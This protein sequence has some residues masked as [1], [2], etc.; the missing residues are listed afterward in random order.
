MGSNEGEHRTP[1]RLAWGRLPPHAAMGE[2]VHHLGSA[3]FQRRKGRLVKFPAQLLVARIAQKR[4]G[5]SFPGRR[6]HCCL[7][8]PW[9]SCPLSLPASAVLHPAA[10]TVHHGGVPGRAARPSLAAGEYAGDGDGAMVDKALL[11]LPVVDERP[12][13][14]VFQLR[15]GGREGIHRSFGE[16][17]AAR[18]EQLTLAGDEHI[19]AA[20]VA[21]GR[22]TSRWACARRSRRSR[23]RPRRGCSCNSARRARRTAPPPH[24]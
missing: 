20:G 13:G 12:I 1:H 4:H 19:L 7:R 23:T 22:A 16:A 21:G 5:S 9:P 8:R 11:R 17:D 2:R 24:Q 15:P 10:N 14:A 3:H 6:R 18:G